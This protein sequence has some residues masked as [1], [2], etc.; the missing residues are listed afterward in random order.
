MARRSPKGRDSCWPLI[1]QMEEGMLLMWEKEDG[2]MKDRVV[3]AGRLHRAT[4]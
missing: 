4:G 1:R 3:R 2:E